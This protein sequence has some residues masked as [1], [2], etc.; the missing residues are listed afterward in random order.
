MRIPNYIGPHSVYYCDSVVTMFKDVPTYRDRIHGYTA[1]D[2]V[3]YIVLIIMG[4]D[5][6]DS[7]MHLMNA[8]WPKCS[9]TS[10]HVIGT[11][12]V[13]EHVLALVSS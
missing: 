10:P 7:L 2:I 3:Q 12:I 8:I 1:S 6:E 9:E 13:M 4:M 11:L 5:C